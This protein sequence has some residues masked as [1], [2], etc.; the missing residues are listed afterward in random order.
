M[1]KEAHTKLLHTKKGL[2]ELET[3]VS[4][5]SKT[6]PDI[7]MVQTITGQYGIPFES[8]FFLQ[9]DRVL[10]FLDCNRF[11]RLPNIKILSKE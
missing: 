11:E 2:T 4:E 10:A 1:A 7:K 3:L 8:D 9:I 5:L 6:H